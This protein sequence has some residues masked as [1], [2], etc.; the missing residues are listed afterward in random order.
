M[1][2]S[3]ISLPEQFKLEDVQ[4]VLNIII[5]LLSTLSVFVLGLVCWLDASAKIAKRK[6]ID[7]SS[8]LTIG[9]IGEALDVLFLL[10]LNFFSSTRIVA[11][12][13]VVACLTTTAILS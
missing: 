8:L 5:S 1:A 3:W 6:I 12:C 7:V 11:Q 10:K 4:A 13:V 2:K 9:S